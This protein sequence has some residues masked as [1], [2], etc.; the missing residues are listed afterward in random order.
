[1]H[2]AAHQCSSKTNEKGQMKTLKE[3]NLAIGKDVKESL[4]FLGIGKCIQTKHL[5]WVAAMS[6]P[7]KKKRRGGQRQRLLAANPERGAPFRQPPLT[8]EL[9]KYLVE[10]WAIGSMSPQQVQR[11]AG[12]AIQDYKTA[13]GSDTTNLPDLEKLAAL[14]QSGA[15]PQNVH[16]DLMH[17]VGDMTFVAATKP[18][19]LPFKEKESLQRIL[20][21]HEVFSSLYR[22][23]DKAWAKTM[24]GYELSNLP[25]F[26]M[27]A[28]SHPCFE[29]S[30]LQEEADGWQ[31]WCIPCTFHG[32][33]V[34]VSGIGKVWS[35]LMTSFSWSS[36]LSQ[37]YTS[38][39]QHYIWSVTD[40]LKTQ[41]TMNE[42]F[43]ILRWSFD[44]M[45][46]GKFPH[47][48]HQGKL[49]PKGSQE[50]K[51]AGSWLA[52]GFR[53]I[54][55]N[56]T[57][58]LDYLCSV[59]QLPRWSKH[60]NPCTLCLCKGG[61]QPGTWQDFRFEASWLTKLWTAKAWLD[62]E[63][64]S[65]NPIFTGKGLTGVSVALDYMHCKYLGSDLVQYGACMF[66]LT[67]EVMPKTK[68]ENLAD[69][70][71]Y[72]KA[73]QKARSEQNPFRYCNKM[74]MF[75]RK[76]GPHKLR[77]KA[78]EAKGF[79]RTLLSAWLH[80]SDAA[81][82]I[83]KRIALMLKLTCRMEDIID[84]HKDSMRFPPKAA[85]DFQKACF[86]MFHL[87]HGLQ[88]HFRNKGNRK[89]FNLTSKCH[90]LCHIAINSKHLNPRKTWCFQGED[91]MKRVQ[92]L[93]QSCLRR[94]NGMDA[95]TK[96]VKHLRLAMHFAWSKC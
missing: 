73:A 11:I 95:T 60:D 80:F 30:P 57:G 44:C 42:F 75:I 23:Y 46:T 12:K 10:T 21:P 19:S 82:P 89:V 64:R 74:T 41:S 67:H 92:R 63:E 69:L 16:K 72:L 31:R 48:N 81:D 77:A 34:P 94:L 70:W 93:A 86:S 51:I 56:I 87:Q 18:Y 20:L 24:V 55:F 58:D 3:K 79:G 71:S 53:G 17:Y 78:A 88:M 47:T 90:F 9:A 1:M 43:Q 96:M 91:Q 83:H 33:G 15:Q 84:E 62:W 14:G 49:Y 6:E 54:L 4:M 68:T 39:S 5:F 85:E 28:K 61:N 59:L 25:A 66:L 7:P 26:W 40:S 52:G 65:D 38:E 22:N 35:K 13:A 36:M 8:S 27:G 50:A 76:Q 37:G 2:W 29:A 32:D 45:F